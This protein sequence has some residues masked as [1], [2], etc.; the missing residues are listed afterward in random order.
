MLIGFDVQ[1]NNDENGNGI[2]DSVVTWN[3][4]TH[5]G[6]QNTSGLGVLLLTR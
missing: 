1:V 5:Q 2:R 3:D 4:S 6:Y